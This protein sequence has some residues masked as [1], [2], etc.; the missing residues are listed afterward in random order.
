MKKET[1]RFGCGCTIPHETWTK[2]G[3]IPLF[4]IKKVKLKENTLIISV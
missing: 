2:K 1:V 3:K 4:K